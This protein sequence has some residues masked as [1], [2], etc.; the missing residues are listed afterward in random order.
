MKNNR[1]NEKLLMF[2][3]C[4]IPITANAGNCLDWGGYDMK[5]V[6]PGGNTTTWTGTPDIDAE[7]QVNTP[8]QTSCVI[9]TQ[10]V[11]ECYSFPS[12]TQPTVIWCRVAG[13]FTGNHTAS[14]PVQPA[15][16][17]TGKT[18]SIPAANDPSG[19]PTP[20]DPYGAQQPLTE[21]IEDMRSSLWVAM[22]DIKSQTLI[23]LE[24]IGTQISEAITETSGVATQAI[25]TFK[26]LYEQKVSEFGAEFGIKMN[27]LKTELEVI[28][29]NVSS[30]TGAIYD[31]VAGTQEV[32]NSVD[33]MHSSLNKQTN[34]II[35]HIDT[36]AT[37]TTNQ[38]DTIAQNEASQR[39]LIAQ[40]QATLNQS[41]ASTAETQRNG[42][43]VDA[44]N[45]RAGIALSEETQRNQIADRLVTALNEVKAEIDGINTN[46]GDDE[47]VTN[48][49][50][51]KCLQVTEPGASSEI[52]PLNLPIDI[53]L[54]NL[55]TISGCPA[56]RVLNLH[57]FSVPISYG[58][59]CNAASTYMRPLI[60][61]L[62]SVASYMVFI[63]GLQA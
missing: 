7:Y 3:I 47:C 62:A 8:D 43:A 9:A 56:D 15:T 21:S 39:D 28:S 5:F 18:G 22:Y 1:I 49:Q 50:L 19:G 27:E 38:L 54:G 20:I 37:N 4:I 16:T 45:Q 33:S 60:L 25:N 48:P 30:F 31:V 26:D 11:E 57:G 17:S 12:S 46:T 53:Q 13:T 24:G 14:T 41:I 59:V 40:N 34:G 32:K 51:A 63:R 36:A 6:A 52:I 44:Q 55:N 58:G 35:D 61:L 23:K 42:I 10:T 2:F 29:S